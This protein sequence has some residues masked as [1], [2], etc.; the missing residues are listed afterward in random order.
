MT[1]SSCWRPWMAFASASVS[2]TPN[3]WGW[4]KATIAN[5]TAGRC[6]SGA[7]FRSPLI[8]RT[9]SL[10]LVAARAAHGGEAGEAKDRAQAPD[11]AHAAQ[12]LRPPD[13]LFFPLGCHARP[14]HW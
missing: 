11:V 8:A 2:V 5:P 7:L 10:F 4:T 14:R 3:V 1:S 13:A 9:M 12:T 6:A